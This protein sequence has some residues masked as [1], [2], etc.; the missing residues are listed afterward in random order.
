MTTT[1]APPEPTRTEPVD[2]IPFLPDDEPSESAARSA[3][4]AVPPPRA[5]RKLAVFLIAMLATL[6]ILLL[7]VPWQQNVSGAG[8]VSALDPLDRTQV[9]PA[10]VSGR[11]VEL[12]V[13]EGDFVQEGQKIAEMADQDPDYAGRLLQQLELAG[14]KARAARDMIAF[15]DQQLV[16]LE[17]AREQA[18]TEASAELDVAIEKVRAAEQDLYA[19][20]AEYEQKLADRERKWTLWQRGVV[21]ELE[22]QKAEADYKAAKAKVESNKAKVEQARNEERAKMAAVGK[23][24]SDQLAKIESTKSA[25]EDA[26][27]KAAL[28]EKEETEATTKV[29]R[30]RTQLVRA[31]RAGY[32][33]RVHA[34]SSAELLSQGEPLIELIPRT[35]ELAVELW[36]RGMDAPLITPGRKV[37][38]QFE[39]WPAV[40]FAGWPSVAVGTFGGVV[41][42]V[43]A[44]GTPDGRFRTLIVPDPDDEPW[45][46]QRYLRQGGRVSGWVL[47]DEVSLGYEIWRQL[48]AFPPSVANAPE[49]SVMDAEKPSKPK[50]KDAAK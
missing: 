28:A 17:D 38:L 13:R 21:S 12:L 7:F 2:T 26:R 10:P 34:A 43:D 22:F 25:R 49:P 47:L 1:A 36:V 40:Q 19:A 4:A 18:V 29:E 24:A 50:T 41:R 9:I 14:Q 6:P 44:H 48:N 8:R 39:G 15:Y 23:V 27:Q 31:P 37:R 46:D 42:V 20:E 30:Q 45:P 3:L 33:L 11:L 32:V 35:D 16:F 5:T